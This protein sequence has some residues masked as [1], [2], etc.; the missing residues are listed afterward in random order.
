MIPTHFEGYP[1]TGIGYEAFRNN[2]NIH[3]IT[4]PKTLTSI[5]EYAF[6]DCDQLDMVAIPEGMTGVGD[7]AFNSCGQLN[8]VALPASLTESIYQSFRDCSIDHVFYSGTEEQWINYAK[9]DYMVNGWVDVHTGATADAIQVFDNTAC[10]KQAIFRCGICQDV[11]FD[12][13]FTGS[14]NF[15]NGACTVCGVDQNLQYRIAADGVA[16]TGYTGTAAELTIPATIEGYPVVAIDQED[17]RDRA[18][19]NNTNLTK[20]VLPNSITYIGVEAFYGCT[21]LQSINIPAGV[22]ILNRGVFYNC[23]SL[24]SIVIPEG[25]IAINSS[26]FYNCKNLQSVTIPQSVTEIGSSAFYY[27]EKLEKIELPGVVRIGGDAFEY[28]TGLKSVSFGKDIAYVGSYAFNQCANIAEVHITDLAGWLG[29]TFDGYSCSPLS[30]GSNPR[31][32]YLNGELVTKVVIPEGVTQIPYGAFANCLNITEVTIPSSVTSIGSVAFKNCMGLSKLVIPEGVTFIGSEAF[33]GCKNMHSVTLPASLT[34]L[35]NSAFSNCDNLANIYLSN[36]EAWL[37]VKFGENGNSTPMAANDLSKNLYLNGKLLLDLV[38]PEG[39][40]EIPKCAFYYCT[41]L[42]SVTIP[43]S[44]T[45]IGNSAFYRC[46]NIS[47]LNMG[48]NVQSIGSYAFYNCKKMKAIALPQTLTTI[49]NYAFSGGQSLEEIVIPDS[50]NKMGEYVFQESS[51]L[52]KV[53]LGR[54]ITAIP[55]GTFY[56]CRSLKDVTIPDTITAIDESAFYACTGMTKINLP[57]SIKSIGQSAFSECSALTELNLPNSVTTI[58]AS[59]F[60]YCYSLRHLTIPGSV[61]SIGANAFQYCSSLTDVTFGDGVESIGSHAF[62][63]CGSLVYVVI[64]D[65]VHTISNNVFSECNQLWHVLYKGSVSDWNSITISTENER[66]TGAIRHANAKGNEISTTAEATC[67]TSIQCKCSFCA[68]EYA[69]PDY[70]PHHNYINDVCDACGLLRNMEYELIDNTIIIRRYW[71]SVSELMIPSNIA[72]FPVVAIGDYA[73]EGCGN[74]TSVTIPDSVKTIGEYAFFCCTNLTQI[75]IGSGVKTIGDYAFS[76]CLALTQVTI[77]DNVTKLGAYAFEWCPNLMSITLGDGLTT[78]GKNVFAN[79]PSLWHILYQGSQSKWSKL[80]VSTK[81]TVHYNATGDEIEP[82]EEYTCTTKAIYK[83]NTCNKRFLD[84]NFEGEHSFSE[85]KCTVCGASETFAYTVSDAGLTI[86]SYEA[87][88]PLAV[89]P[90]VLDGVT[91]IAIAENAFADRA[92]VTCVAIP[93]TVK[94]IGR[95]AFAGCT[96]LACVIYQG[97]SSDKKF[98]E[99]DD[100]NTYLTKAKWH[101]DT[102]CVPVVTASNDANGYPVLSWKSAP[103]VLKY[104]IYRSTS[105]KSGFELL[106]ETTQTSFTDTD[107]TRGDRYYYKVRAINLTEAGSAECAA[108]AAYVVLAAPEVTIDNDAATG[109]PELTWEPAEGAKKYEVYRATTETGK[110]AKLTTT[111]KLSYVDSKAS[112]GKTYFY[113]VKSIGTSSSYNSSLT[114]ALNATA[115][116]AQ[117]AVKTSVNAASGAPTL[118]WKKITGAVAYRIYGHT[119]DGESYLLSEQTGLTFTD[120]DAP[121]DSVCTYEVDAVASNESCNSRPGNVVTAVS[122]IAAPQIGATTDLIGGKP[123]VFWDEVEG[124]VAYQITRATSKSGSYK[125]VDTISDLEF[126]DETAAVGKTYYYKVIAVGENSK[127]AASA[128][129]NA[130]CVCAAPAFSTEID[131][132]TGK[133]ML[134]WDK[135][136]GAKKY[137]V[138]RSTEEDG[139]YVKLTTT[140]KLSY[141][142]TKAIMGTPYYYKVTAVASKSSNNS[143]S[144]FIESATAICA[145]PA[146]TLSNDAETGAPVLTWKAV[147]G[148]VEYQIL[149]DDEV[150]AEQTELTYIDLDTVLDGLYNYRVVAVAENTE[151]N[152]ISGEGQNFYASCAAPVI[153]VSL[154]GNKPLIEWEAVDGAVEYHIYRSTKAA[155]G[156]KQIDAVETESYHDTSAAK[157]KTYYYKVVAATEVSVSAFSDYAKIKSK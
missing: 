45:T 94:T 89:I 81:A 82:C 107:V 14:H 156:Y 61:S 108:K 41:D 15:V 80:S 6:Y 120:T 118:T 121:V 44:V 11:I 117:P 136:S 9:P 92:D 18:F 154:D 152:S 90:E 127:S 143:L 48:K 146:L 96:E 102:C 28:C 93:A 46:E 83:C 115:I 106:T 128:Y 22:T 39:I 47:T 124:A 144:S 116:C 122:G 86:T 53:V 97:T 153:S 7:Y 119:E 151:W 131:E 30:Y 72:G 104:E 155:S 149:R 27:C 35:G 113:K 84:K 25:V 21:N 56:W 135:V 19:K 10:T 17:T 66:L 51:G 157:G 57:G 29:T 103:C 98:L 26:A 140:T 12:S 85:G 111:T 114:D 63:S 40:T 130:K 142:D 99:I 59:A 112:F 1:V 141:T 8:V 20:V 2:D 87:E 43:D 138:Y 126:V 58:S 24:E 132:A 54:G 70:E 33:Y 79:S 50:V 62:A 49:G 91:V 110:Y 77:P 78:V 137:T 34:E 36:I 38:I 76:N 150:I 101:Y 123:I 65:S 129:K 5:G 73:F 68:A 109:K 55:N 3:R 67:I 32:L 42:Q 4:F 69:N 60:R 88:E 13:D 31:K 37:K 148:A 71:G 64:P 139:T 52:K 23:S 133:P 16:I 100:G 147:A 134:S 95:D 125:T 74:L 75:N 105:S 145:Q